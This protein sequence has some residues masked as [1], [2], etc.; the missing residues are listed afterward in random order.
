M[1][2]GVWL[3]LIAIAF[4]TRPLWPMVEVRFAAVAWDMWL[5]D[6]FLVPQLNGEVCSHKPPLLYWL[7]HLGWFVFGVSE[8]W[9]RL[10]APLFGLAS[11][12]MTYRLG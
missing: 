5:H 2:I 8:T 12:A 9:L 11:V 7:V 10:V 6:S 1:W 4:W 3:I